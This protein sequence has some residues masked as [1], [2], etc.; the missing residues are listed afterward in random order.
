M[1]AAVAEARVDARLSLKAVAEK[2]HV[3][4][5]TVFQWEHG[6]RTPRFD[7]AVE[8]ARVVGMPLEFTRGVPLVASRPIPR[9]ARSVDEA[10]VLRAIDGEHIDLSVRERREAVRRLDRGD[11]S[12]AQ[13]GRRLGIPTRSVQRHRAALRAE[14]A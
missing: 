14:A 7:L 13:I 2:M 8:Y 9:R 12:A 4:W 6:L 1:I 10:R 3:N 5:R 11:M